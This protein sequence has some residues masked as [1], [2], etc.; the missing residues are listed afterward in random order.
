[1]AAQ[2]KQD[3]ELSKLS[4]EDILGHLEDV[5]AQ[6]EAG[7]APLE[8]ALATF[9]KGI[10]LSRHGSSRLDDAEARIEV[11]LKNEDGVSTRPLEQEPATD[12]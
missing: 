3:R 12:E 8:E 10:A 5:V 6:L 7:D 9:E 1:M 11:L 4:F 2:S